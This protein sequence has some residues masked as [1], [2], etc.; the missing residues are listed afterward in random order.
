MGD[1]EDLGLLEDEGG[2]LGDDEGGEPS[3]SEE[4]SP[5]EAPAEEEAP[6]EEIEERE[7][8]ED[9]RAA[10][11]ALPTQLRKALREFTAAN[12]DFAKAHPRLER[13]LSAALFKSQQTDRYGG[14][15]TLRAAAEA[16]EQHGGPQGIAERAEEVEA[17]RVMD[18]G[19]REG[20][21]VLINTIAEQHPEGFKLLVA[22]AIQKLESMDLAA[23][24]RA[25]SPDMVRTLDRCGFFRTMAALDNAIAGE[26][27]EEIVRHGNTAKQFLEE[28]RNF[29][30]QTKAP[31][32]LKAERESLQQDRAEVQKERTNTFYG[33]VRSMVNNEVMAY[34][35]RLLRQELAGRKLQVS[36]AN[37]VRKQINEDLAAA[38]NTAQGYQD[39]YKATMAQGD[40]DRAVRFITA[41]AKQKLPLVVKRVLRD[42]N[43]A[44]SGG[45]TTLR[46]TAGTAGEPKGSSTVAGRPKTAEVDFTR[47]DKA[48]Y[49]ASLGR[50]G[51]AYL[52][53]GKQA[54]W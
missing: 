2:T 18:Q 15:Q 48:T 38:V 22:P 17:S 47:T 31:D 36:T 27:F 26:R 3:E 28:L 24:D 39:R 49:L 12:P 40:P 45:G 19:F 33:G 30:A 4:E 21:P 41:A 34:T 52:K 53:N 7:P 20:D 14:L 1:A 9:D 23:H 50:H 42:F 32:P 13:Q 46:R 5:V 35:N 10:T 37:R 43:L 25:V 6:Q 54:K 11:R 44:R 29:A 51:V 8:R 16:V